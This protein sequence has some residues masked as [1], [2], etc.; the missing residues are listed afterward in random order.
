[1]ME[2]PKINYPCV[3]YYKIIGYDRELITNILP[4]VLEK[5]DYTFEESHK[6][7]TGKYISF[8]FSAQV[9]SEE[10]RNKIFNILK[11]IPTVKIVL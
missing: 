5:L 11:N 9:N 2:K 8:N 4:I 6:S 10:E 7:K 1:M 3:W